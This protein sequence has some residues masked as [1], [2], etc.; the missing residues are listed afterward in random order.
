MR[1]N[2]IASVIDISVVNSLI[3]NK[4]A[5]IINETLIHFGNNS[6]FVERGK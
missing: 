3:I 6:E 2:A 5:P 1:P 4:S